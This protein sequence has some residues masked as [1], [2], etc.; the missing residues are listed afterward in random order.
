MKATN[1]DCYAHGALAAAKL[2]PTSAR[3]L[4]DERRAG[5]VGECFER[6]SRMRNESEA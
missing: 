6:E 4:R 2:S 5:T 3:P 1:R